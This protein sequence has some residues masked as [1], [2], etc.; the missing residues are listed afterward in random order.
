M[1]GISSKREN[2]PFISFEWPWDFNISQNPAT[3]QWEEEEKELCTRKNE[4]P[5]GFPS[6]AVRKF[7]YLLRWLIISACFGEAE[8]SKR[9]T[10]IH[11]PP[12]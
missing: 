11:H 10:A 6:G 12:S 2:S 5:R 1:R 9:S 7:D 3:L 8:Q 4:R